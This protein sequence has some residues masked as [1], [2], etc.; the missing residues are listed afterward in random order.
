MKGRTSTDNRQGGGGSERKNV[1]RQQTGEVV[2]VKGRTSTD[3]RQG[4]WWK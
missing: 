1:N 4:R 2:E 3:N